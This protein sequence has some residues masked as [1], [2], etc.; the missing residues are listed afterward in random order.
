[1]KIKPEH[2]THMKQAIQ[3]AVSKEDYQEHKSFVIQE[4]KAKDIDKRMRWDV[5]A[6]AKLTPFLCDTLYKYMDDSHID[7]A[8]KSIQKELYS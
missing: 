1:M 8:L 6:A 2:Y 5:C 3:K 4:G 7:T